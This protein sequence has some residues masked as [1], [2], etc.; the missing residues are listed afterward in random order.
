M[1]GVAQGLGSRFHVPGVGL[2]QHRP[3]GLIE[4][5]LFRHFRHGDI[6]GDFHHYGAGP[7]LAQRGERAAHHLRSPLGGVDLL[8]VF[9]HTGV[10]GH[11]AEMGKDSLPGTRMA[12]RQQEHRHRVGV[13]SSYAGVGVF[14]SRAVLHGEHSHSLTVSGPA[15]SVGNAHPDPLLAANNRPDARLGSRLNH[16]SCGEATKVFNPFPL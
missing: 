15:E 16:R 12:Q 10:V 8:D 6:G 5:V 1:P 2:R 3:A 14:R 13:G 9:V 11:G 4:E 7:A